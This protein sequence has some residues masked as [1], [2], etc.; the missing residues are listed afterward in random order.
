MYERRPHD[1][2]TGK[3][4]TRFPLMDSNGDVITED[5]RM[6]ADR[7]LAGIRRELGGGVMQEAEQLS[8]ALPPG[9]PRTD[10]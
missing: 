2:R 7:R 4:R 5:R 9:Q 6:L 1:R 10:R 8:G 3:T